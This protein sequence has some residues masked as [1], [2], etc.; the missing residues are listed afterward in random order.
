[1]RITESQ[2]RKIIK[3][4]AARAK[5]K[6]LNEEFGQGVGAVSAE[7]QAAI[8]MIC[9]GWKQQFNPSDPSMDAAGGRGAWDAQCEAACEDL[10]DLVESLIMKTE[11]ALHNGE[12]Y[13]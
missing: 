2:L 5:R 4:E 7:M 6:H 3:E 13:R 10:A 1:M 8:D 9:D 12:Y 11:S